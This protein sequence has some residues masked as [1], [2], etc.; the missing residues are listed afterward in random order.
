MFNDSDSE[1]NEKQKTGLES[2][3][4]QGEEEENRETIIH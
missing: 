1:D 4:Y 2:N 3:K